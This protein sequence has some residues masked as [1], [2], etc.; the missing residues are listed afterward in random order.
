MA[1]V[2]GQAGGAAAAVGAGAAATREAPAL[3]GQRTALHTE[4]PQRDSSNSAMQQLPASREQ[5][6]SAAMLRNEGTI[7]SM[8]AARVQTGSPITPNCWL[9]W[10][11]HSACCQSLVHR[12][13]TRQRQTR[14]REN[15]RRLR[16]LPSSRRK[17]LTCVKRCRGRDGCKCCTGMPRSVVRMPV[18]T[19]IN[20]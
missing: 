20:Q 19:T 10:R 5:P 18:Q 2:P 7:C 16:E 15:T 9:L 17:F 12:N 4:H 11:R 14:T 8:P 3:L 1:G 13:L 6:S